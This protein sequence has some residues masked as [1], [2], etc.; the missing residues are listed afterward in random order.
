MRWRRVKDQDFL[1]S[2]L[3]RCGVCR[4]RRVVTYS[5]VHVLSRKAAYCCG[6]LERAVI[7][8][9]VCRS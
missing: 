4:V 2:R 5:T 8:W 9:R 1:A 3:F 7:E 6:E